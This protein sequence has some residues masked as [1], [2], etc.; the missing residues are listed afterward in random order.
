MGR[1]G[2]QIPKF[3]TDY[4]KLQALAR[5]T[6]ARETGPEL[7]LADMRTVSGPALIKHQRGKNTN[8]LLAPQPGLAHQHTPQT[9]CH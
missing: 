2:N 9:T 4:E 6:P 8:S 1:S 3:V 7:I 5:E